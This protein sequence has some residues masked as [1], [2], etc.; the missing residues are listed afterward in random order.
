[1]TKERLEKIYNI[2]TNQGLFV[3][4]AYEVGTNVKVDFVCP[5]HPEYIQTVNLVTFAKGTKCKYCKMEQEYNHIY[6]QLKTKGYALLSEKYSY[7]KSNLKY[8]CEKHP[9][10]IQ[11]MSWYN[12]KKGNG[13][14]LCGI[15][16]CSHSR[17]F[18]YQY[19]KEQ[20]SSNGYELLSD[21]YVNATTKLKYR[22][23]NHSNKELYITYADFK[24][25][26][27]CPYC[28]GTGTS[29]PEQFIYYSIKQSFN[30]AENRT[31]YFGYEFDIAVPEL[32]LLIEY[33]GE[34]YHHETIDKTKE[35]I[36]KK[37]NWNFLLIQESKD[38][39]LKQ[40][41]VITNNIIKMYFANG[42][43]TSY[44]NM[45]LDLIMEYINDNF[46]QEISFSKLND[47][48]SYVTI[49]NNCKK[50]KEEKSLYTTHPEL[51]NE[52]DYKTNTPLTPKDVSYASHL[53]VSWK[54][55]KC[56]HVWTASIQNRTILNRGCPNCN[57]GVKTKVD[58]FDLNG[59]YIKTFESMSEAANSIGVTNKAISNVCR[60]KSKTSGGYIW[61]KH[62]DQ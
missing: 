11:K 39:T 42:R 32:K 1:M 17:K 12:F 30:K 22:C 28:I 49:L 19:I 13:C 45:V 10:I 31:K 14:R 18:D 6:N 40:F 52:W 51:C 29:F 33:D 56:N 58:Q 9:D 38:K 23:P 47:M 34:L 44:L 43:K 41:P 21:T 8:T 57:G 5:H 7:D 15:E 25:G 60:K 20:F 48:D 27:R 46:N 2:G 61:R 26:A 53:M 62:I 54:C 37:N 35:K 3:S 59:K 36:V 4:N 24:R 16:K 50:I 55:H